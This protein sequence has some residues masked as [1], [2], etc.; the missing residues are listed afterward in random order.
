MF[1]VALALCAPI[2]RSPLGAEYGKAALMWWRTLFELACSS[3]NN[4]M[5]SGARARRPPVP[6]AWIGLDWSPALPRNP[7]SREVALR[8]ATP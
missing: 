5:T 1:P 3:L 4:S 2:Q 6:G 7:G 8:R